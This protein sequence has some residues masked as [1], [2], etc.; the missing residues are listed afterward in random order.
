[1]AKIKE[2]T[3]KDIQRS[4]LVKRETLGVIETL[5]GKLA[6][7]DNDVRTDYRITG[8]TDKQRTS[9]RTGE[10]LWEDEEK[11]VPSYEDKWECVN[12]TA[13]ELT[14]EDLAKLDAIELL[15]KRLAEMI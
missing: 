3:V 14:E 6:E 7:L 11:T 12:K 15:S 13:D 9:W 4:I 2:N 8:K 1:M 5:L 10:L